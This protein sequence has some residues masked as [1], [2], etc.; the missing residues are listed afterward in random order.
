MSLPESYP[1]IRY[2]LAGSLNRQYTLLPKG[3]T[4]FDQCGGSLAYAAGGL[5]LWE[6]NVGL[7]GRVGSDY[8]QDWLQ[9][10]ESKGFDIRGI[11]VLKTPLELRSFACYSDYETRSTLEPLSHFARLGISVPSSLLGFNP[12]PPQIDSR[13]QPNDYTLRLNDFP[14]DYKDAAAAHICPL[15]YLSHLLL[16]SVLR[17]GRV[18]TLTLDPGENYMLPAFW[19]DIPA[20]VKGLTA[21]LV[22][23]EKLTALFQGRSRDVWE[24][25]EALCAYGCEM[26]VIQRGGRGQYLYVHASRE[27]WVIPA[28]PSRM[29]NPTGAGDAFS[30]GFLAGYRMYYQPVLAACYGNI[31]ASFMVEGNSPFY[32][33]D[34]MPG[35]A[36]ARLEALRSTVHRV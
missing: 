28:Y 25:A 29:A 15:D 23:E 35:L 12:Q 36:N 14:T 4:E 20:V 5:S 1:F 27:R 11:Q 9:K 26:M 17:Q 2:V 13:T 33:M 31:S 18:T 16:P 10:I 22:S 6:K 21:M 7:I 32:P 34:A 8:P 30:G 24:M 19:D 3:Q